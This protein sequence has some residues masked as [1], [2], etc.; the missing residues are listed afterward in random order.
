MAASVGSPEK[1]SD[2]FVP[3]VVK[4]SRMGNVSIYKDTQLDT[5]MEEP[6]T[7]NKQNTQEEERQEEDEGV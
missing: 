6:S 2:E 5:S 3:L 4:I 1:A 7:N